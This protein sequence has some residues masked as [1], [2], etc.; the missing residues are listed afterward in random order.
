MND[1]TRPP[2]TIRTRLA[3]LVLAC[4]L[5]SVLVLLVLVH[6]G[7]QRSQQQL[8]QDAYSR[9]RA[10]A[11]AVDREVSAVAGS[12]E[13]LSTSSHI[14]AAQWDGLHAQARQMQRRTG[15]R[16]VLADAD[17]GQG[18]VDS[19]ADRAGRAG[20]AGAAAIEVPGVP[21]A[22]PRD[23]RYTLSA[24]LSH[25]HLTMLLEEQDL[26]GSWGVSLF[27]GDGTAL[28]S[29]DGPV[30]APARLEGE[31]LRHAAGGPAG[32]LLPVRGA[33]GVRLLMAFDRPA[34]VPWIV[35]VAMPAAEAE[36]TTLAHS[37]LAGLG[38]LAAFAC[39]LALAWS[40]GRRIVGAV[41]GLAAIDAPARTQPAYFR[42][43]DEVRLALAGASRALRESQQQSEARNQRLAH[44]LDAAF[45]AIVAA[46][47]D[48][49]I[50]LF[51]PA[52]ERMF[53]FRRDEVL[54][55]P[56]ELLL[57]ER[58]RAA[59]VAKI[60]EFDPSAG[61]TLR[62]RSALGRRAD[63]SEF[64]IEASFAPFQEDGRLYYTAVVRDVT[65]RMQREQALLRSNADLQQFAYAASHDLKAPLRTIAGF[66]QVLRRVYAA[67]LE[68]RAQD[69]LERIARA[70]RQLDEL[71]DAL[72][73][74][75]RLD[76]AA[77]TREPADCG[78]LVRQALQLLQPQIE[79][80]GMQVEVGDLPTVPG[81]PALLA[82]LFLNLVGNALRYH[83]AG[84]PPVLR[85]AAER[86][87]DR[88]VLAFDDNGL[89]VDASQRERIFAGFV[90]LHRHE[91][92]EGTG[93]GL[94]ICR[95]IVERHAGT[96][97]VEGKPTPGSVFKVA[98][99]AA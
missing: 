83:R 8:Y 76:A 95:R 58:L 47:A 42:E 27:R 48:Q 3:A 9:A 97:W 19:A 40:V 20:P 44:I 5:P 61:A 91:E 65:V 82:H 13:A 72:L 15:V 86:Q 45:D 84:V 30:E 60:R 94:A 43:A 7:Y 68:G 18:V 52:A 64:P 28:A 51:N 49:R 4:V 71:T 46:D 67:H 74:F 81:D 6:D 35:A 85:I 70:A 31:T 62:G 73:A 36:S 22:V 34:R 14:P 78:Q 53:G 17:S 57:P 26:P 37:L 41:E 56:L 16:F 63:G 54:G 12:L 75:A 11:L 99:P 32:R 55:Q 10:A 77:D 69:M 39:G 21:V 92:I 96:I 25:V 89:G 24:R 59:Y 23:G 2:A 98:L 90:R 79:H 38:A 88:W 80:A 33:D 1:R 93:M 87:E 29:L 50:L 66:V